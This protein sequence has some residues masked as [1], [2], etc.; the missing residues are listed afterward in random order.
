M[1]NRPAYRLKQ[2][3]YGQKCRGGADGKHH[4]EKPVKGGAIIRLGN[5]DGTGTT[6][7]RHQVRTPRQ[8]QEPD[9]TGPYSL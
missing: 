3:R 9:F 8:L 7:I 4:Y 1:A 6:S 5:G 2:N